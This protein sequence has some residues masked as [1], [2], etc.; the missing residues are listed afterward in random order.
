MSS[1]TYTITLAKF[2]AALGE[3]DRDSRVNVLNE[4]KNKLLGDEAHNFIQE[5]YMNA[6]WSSTSDFI[7]HYAWFSADN[8]KNSEK[9]NRMMKEV[10]DAW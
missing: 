9:L 2:K 4:M 3:M 8:Y 6:Q 7:Q 5:L 1:I 10:V